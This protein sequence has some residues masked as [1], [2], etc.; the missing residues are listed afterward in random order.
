M[1]EET[2][3]VNVLSYETLPCPECGAMLE[4]V[5][6]DPDILD[7]DGESFYISFD[8]ECPECGATFIGDGNGDLWGINLRHIGD[9]GRC[10]YETMV[11]PGSGKTASKN[12]S[13]RKPATKARKPSAGA[14]KPSAKRNTARRASGTS[15]ARKPATGRPSAKRAPARRK[16][17][18]KTSYR[19]RYRDDLQKRKDQHGNEEGQRMSD[20]RYSEAQLSR[21]AEWI[22][23]FCGNDDNLEGFLKWMNERGGVA[24]LMGFMQYNDDPGVVIAEYWIREYLVDVGMSHVSSRSRK[25]ASA[26]ARRP[27]VKRKAPQRANGTSK[28]RK[29]ATGRPNTKKRAGARR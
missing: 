9:N 3:E 18:S 19:T 25:G 5:D 1:K 12:I 21:K 17:V 7:F 16:T 13:C 6:D 11:L 14:R 23:E 28:A 20:S 29:P 26:G 8:L 10:D 2:I 22:E 4:A 15:K 24:T 27:S